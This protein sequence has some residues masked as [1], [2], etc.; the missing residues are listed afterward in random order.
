MILY[1]L[2]L[3]YDNVPYDFINRELDLLRHQFKIHLDLWESSPGHYH[4]R[5]PKPLDWLEAKKVLLASRC[6][7][8]YKRL[9]VRI[10][11][12]PIRTGEKTAFQEDGTLEFVKPRPKLIPHA[13]AVAI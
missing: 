1:L 12:F 11:A 3:D 10:Q 2:S 13:G 7:P 9:C 5:C 4:I 8:A 6:S